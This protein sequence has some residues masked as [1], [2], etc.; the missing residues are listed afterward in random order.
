MTRHTPEPVTMAVGGLATG[1]LAN[2]AAT[3]VSW[4]VFDDVNWPGHLVL[5]LPVGAVA[6][7]GGWVTG[8]VLSRRRRR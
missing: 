5:W 3:A 7:A 1:V 8:V 6:L 4:L 2:L